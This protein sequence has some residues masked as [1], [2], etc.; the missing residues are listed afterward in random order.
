MCSCVLGEGIS[1]QSS[2]F[3]PLTPTA[4]TPSWQAPTG[5]AKV[6]LRSRTRGFFLLYLFFGCRTLRPPKQR[7]HL[8]HKARHPEEHAT[9]R[10]RTNRA[11]HL[12]TFASVEM[13]PQ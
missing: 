6:Q 13:L 7:G 8:R 5:I 10:A 11:K 4:P 9:E 1:A 2:G 3:L 12:L